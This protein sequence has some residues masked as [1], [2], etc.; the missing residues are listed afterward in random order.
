MIAW[1]VFKYSN[2]ELEKTYQTDI[3]DSQRT[4]SCAG[5]EL[6]SVIINRINSWLVGYD[7]ISKCAASFYVVNWRGILWKVFLI[8]WDRMLLQIVEEGDFYTLAPSTYHF[9][10]GSH[11]NKK[12][13]HLLCFFQR[14]KNEIELWSEM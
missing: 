12:G 10:F 13:G 6:G 14:Q 4:F 11:Y 9:P 2:K 1:P 5:V 7:V 3:C 8:F